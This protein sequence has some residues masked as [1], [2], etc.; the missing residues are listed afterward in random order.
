MQAACW[1]QWQLAGWADLYIHPGVQIIASPDQDADGQRS[2][3]CIRPT[4]RPTLQDM[5]GSA[6]S[7]WVF[8]SIMW[9]RLYYLFYTYFYR[10]LF[11]H[12]QQP[13][14]SHT[15]PY[16]K[17]S[18]HGSV[19]CSTSGI[20]WDFPD[21]KGSSLIYRAAHW[22]HCIHWFVY[23]RWG[24]VQDCHTNLRFHYI[25]E[26]SV[27]TSRKSVKSASC[28]LLICWFHVRDLLN[29]RQGEDEALLVIALPTNKPGMVSLVFL[30]FAPL[31]SMQL[32]GNPE[33]MY[34]GEQAM[35]CGVLC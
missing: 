21:F 1:N 11:Y 6:P 13:W 15:Q 25:E 27:A 23:K 4:F 35:H 9:M 26:H 18:V 32:Q 3:P 5:C 22:L 2:D 16:I 17:Q 8:R 28:E 30:P 10:K 34:R 19:F 33:F 20:P 7:T 31:I 12:V 14:V 29:R 24:E